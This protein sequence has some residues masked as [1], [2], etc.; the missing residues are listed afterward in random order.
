MNIHRFF[1]SI[2]VILLCISGISCHVNYGT[3]NVN[4]ELKKNKIELD[5]IARLFYNQ[6]NLLAISRIDYNHIMCGK[7]RNFFSEVK[8]KY[9]LIS[10]KQEINNSISFD[11]E[12]NEQVFFKKDYSNIKYKDY[13]LK[14]FLKKYDITEDLFKEIKNFLYTNGYVDISKDK[15]DDA[16]L[17]HI[18]LKDGLLF[19][20]KQDIE[21]NNP[22]FDEL[23]SYGGNWYYF[24]EKL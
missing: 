22:R 11:V 3:E 5:R 16:I 12:G 13:N 1:L 4:K 14:D 15:T 10:T 21:K 19:S 9:F 17:I 7:I 24:K 18:G 2:I 23:I 6:N 20:L 8:T